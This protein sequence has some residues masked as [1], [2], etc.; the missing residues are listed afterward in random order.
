MGVSEVNRCYI[1]KLQQLGAG[2]RREKVAALYCLTPLATVKLH[3][4]VAFFQLEF[5][6]VRIE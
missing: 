3:R 4:A 5:L 6:R 2:S 1:C